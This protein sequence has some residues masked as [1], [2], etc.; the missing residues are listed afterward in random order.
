M[1]KKFF[2]FSMLCLFISC[3]TNK[4]VVRTT[5]TT[6]NKS[7]PVVRTVK[8][9]IAKPS[10]PIVQSKKNDDKPIVNT[11][12]KENQSEVLEATSRVKVTTEIVNN[13][14]DKYKEVA[15]LNMKNHGVPASIALAQAILESGAG[16]GDLSRQA[17]NHFGI[18]C[19]KDWLGE[20]VKHD[21]DAAQECFR[22]YNNVYD[23]YRDYAAFL[24]GRKWYEPL[25]KLEKNDY[26]AWAR[27]LKKA[28]YATDPGYPN[29][30]I[31]L[32]E[33]YQLQRFDAEVLGTEYVETKVIETEKP[34]QVV[35]SNS[36]LHQVEK[37][38]TLYSISKRYNMSIDDLKQK[39]RIS[40]NSIAI[41]Q[42]LQVK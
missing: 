34:K 42:M 39:N 5:K 30:L 7:K 33:R 4:P 19:H 29:K 26:K 8:K 23:S 18:K 36:E 17:N 35:I 15:K 20:S 31:G 14:I 2:L 27:G 37:G 3:G 41:G 1:I 6:V 11:Q 10:E 12:Q 22:K 40:E 9:P 25:F 24:I 13:Y 28:G 38:D 16:T 32:I 21:D